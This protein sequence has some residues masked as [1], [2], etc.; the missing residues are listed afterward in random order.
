M[1]PI[2]ER[3]R[4]PRTAAT[5][6]TLANT[7]TARLTILTVVAGLLT[8]PLV[9]GQDA[10]VGPPPPLGRLVDVGGF[11]M[12]IWC[13]GPD[14]AAPPVVFLPGSGDFSFTWGLVL[15]EVA[16]FT[17]ACAYDKAYEAWSDPGPLP[18]TLRQDAHELRLLLQRAG[19]KGP[20]VLVGA[21]WGGPLA[22]IF[23][24]EF[25]DDVSGMVLVDATDADTVMGRVVDGKGVN[26]RVREDSKGRDVP[27]VQTMQSSPPGPLTADERQRYE[28]YV[29]RPAITKS[30]PPHD[31]LPAKLQALDMWFRSHVNPMRFKTTNQFEGEEFQELF[32][33][34]QKSV[35]PLGDMPLI[36][37]IADGKVARTVD[38]QRKLA[39][40]DNQRDVEK[41]MQKVAQ[42]LL[43]RNGQYLRVQS[44]HEIHL[45][46]P[47]WVIEAVRQVVDASR[48]RT[49]R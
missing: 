6:R 26:F 42:A 35:P 14:T 49:P 13:M 4:R 27:Q 20:Y 24:R 31:R 23:A 1:Q 40:E 48:A 11:R 30:Y 33:D 7:G 41:K 45:Y 36:V 29:G 9:V 16:R 25:R 18:R 43:S 2:I 47:A 38:V 5:G 21:S 37:L 22:R 12:H 32:E 46:R 17:R 19:V 3:R 28:R 39:A 15:P 34:Q 8:L 10:S 44:D